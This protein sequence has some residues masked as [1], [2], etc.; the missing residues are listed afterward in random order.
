MHMPSLHYTASW[1]LFLLGRLQL[2][3]PRAKPTHHANEQ[4]PL[5][6]NGNDGT[7]AD[8]ECWLVTSPMAFENVGFTKGVLSN[9]K[10]ESEK[11]ISSLPEG[12]DIRYLAC[13]DCDCGP[14][15]WHIEAK[16]RDLGADVAAEQE[17]GVQ[18]QRQ[19]PQQQRD[20]REFL[21]DITRCR[22]K[23]GA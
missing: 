7:S 4:F 8:T 23:V 9:G 19:Q 16:G 3:H 11:A 12:A 17:G 10:D 13:A 14:L 1:C 21:I 22:Y 15:G 6:G 18:A 20:T 2:S 5:E